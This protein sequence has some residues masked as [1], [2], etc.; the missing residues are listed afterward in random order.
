MENQYTKLQREIDEKI[1]NRVKN[2]SMF[3][4]LRYSNKNDQF[5]N[6]Y[7]IEAITSTMN[8]QII[9]SSPRISK[10]SY[11]VIENKT[12]TPNLSK[13][14]EYSSPLRQNGNNIINMGRDSRKII[15]I[16]ESRI[17]EKSKE[18]DYKIQNQK[19]EFISPDPIIMNKKIP[20]EIKKQYQNKYNNS[21]F[22][23]SIDTNKRNVLMHFLRNDK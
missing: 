17:P 14:I 9:N 6:F 7:Q 4:S 11:E 16:E 1:K 10:I 22:L 18:N 23:R 13:K 21:E 8:S 19:T 20:Y 3:S 12:K 5:K 2:E 15:S